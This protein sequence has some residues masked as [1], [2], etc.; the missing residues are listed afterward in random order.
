MNALSD[1][2]LINILKNEFNIKI[3]GI[4]Q[5]DRLPTPLRKGFYIINLQSSTEGNGTHWTC[6]YHNKG[7]IIY[8]DSYGFGAPQPVEERSGEIVYSKVDIQSKLS[9]SCGYYCIAFIVYM[10]K[11]PTAE[12]FNRFIKYF[13]ENDIDNEV[14][15]FNILYR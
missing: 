5:K 8:F 7:K 14:D 10:F 9:T 6:F 2:D 11:K 12:T 15:L 13:V 4:Y 1:R 3:R